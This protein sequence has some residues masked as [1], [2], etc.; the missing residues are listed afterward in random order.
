MEQCLYRPVGA[1]IHRMFTTRY[2][3]M[4]LIALFYRATLLSLAERVAVVS[5]ELY[6]R[7]EKRAGAV[8]TGYFGMNFGR[9][10]S[11]LFFEPDAITDLFHRISIGGCIR[12]RPVFNSSWPL[13]HPR[14]L[15][16]LPRHVPFATEV[17]VT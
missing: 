8:L 2:Y 11:R 16:R 10:F 13:R 6:R 12:I 3:M 17:I 7:Q 4:A 9:T 1:L 15:G 5:E 14:K